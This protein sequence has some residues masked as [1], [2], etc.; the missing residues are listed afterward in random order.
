MASIFEKILGGGLGLLGI[1][2]AVADSK[3]QRKAMEMAQRQ[4]EQSM[5][6]IQD[7]I[8]KT[9]GQLFSIYPQI[10]QSQQMGQQAALQALGGSFLPMMDTYRQGNLQAQQALL[11]GLPMANAA[12]LGQSSPNMLFAREIPLNVQALSGLTN[13]QALQFNPITQGL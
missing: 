13:P 6:F 7:Q 9:Q 8:A 3:N 2:G 12:V 1:G 11:A 5:R 10:Q 4:R